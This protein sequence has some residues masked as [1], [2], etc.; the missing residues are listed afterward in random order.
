MA[1]TPR[2]NQPSP[3]DK[4]NARLPELDGATLEWWRY[5]ITHGKCV[6]RVSN[7][8]RK[9]VGYVVMIATYYINFPTVMNNVRLRVATDSETEALRDRLPDQGG[10]LRANGHRIVDCTEGTFAIWSNGFRIV[11]DEDEAARILHDM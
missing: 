2:P 6:W 9:G 3:L 11:W 4:I 5:S 7:L 1:E 8:P 10:S